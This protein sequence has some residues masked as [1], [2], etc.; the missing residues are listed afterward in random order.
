MLTHGPPPKGG[1]KGKP[2][3]ISP[4]GIVIHELSPMEASFTGAL[5]HVLLFLFLL[6]KVEEKLQCLVCLFWAMI[7]SNKKNTIKFEGLLGEIFPYFIWKKSMFD[8]N[9]EKHIPSGEWNVLAQ[10]IL[11]VHHILVNV[12]PCSCALCLTTPCGYLEHLH[13]LGFKN[14]IAYGARTRCAS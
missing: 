9:K 6:P 10:N 1:I 13:G 8:L 3:I 12:A 2:H 4:C 11:F 14:Q 7:S 5:G